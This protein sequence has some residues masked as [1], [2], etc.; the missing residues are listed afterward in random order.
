MNAQDVILGSRVAH[1]RELKAEVA[2]LK[3]ENDRLR[4]ENAELLRHFDMALAAAMDLGG[5][6]TGTFIVVD[7]WNLILGAGKEA[8]S[9]EELEGRMRAHLEANPD[10][11]V[12]IVYDGERE[13]SRNDGR[14]RVSW[15]FGR[16]ETPARSAIS[17]TRE[18]AA[19]QRTR[20]D[21]REAERRFRSFSPA[22]L[23]SMAIRCSCTAISIS[24]A[25]SAFHS[26]RR[27][28]RREAVDTWAI[29]MTRARVMRAAA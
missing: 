17:L 18:T 20:A 11:F 22:F 6:R 7:G 14:L 9:P 21:S 8:R 15:T 10:D 24:S 27:A 19:F 13:G 12:W 16:G 25:D 23:R 3:A 1:L 5:R 28:F 2:K 4:S 26:E 29:T